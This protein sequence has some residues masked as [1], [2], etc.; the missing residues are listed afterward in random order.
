V[1]EY[2]DS[3]LKKQRQRLG[4]QVSAS[5]EGNFGVYRT[6][7]TKSKKLEGDCSCPSELWPCKHIHALRAT[8]ESNLSNFFDFDAWLKQLANGPKANL[9]EAIGN[10]VLASPGFLNVLGVPGFE[11][12]DDGAEDEE[13]YD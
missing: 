2:V 6:H 8:W 12:D 3:P 13:N 1:A 4:K 11:D 7:V 5:I 10:I 9:V